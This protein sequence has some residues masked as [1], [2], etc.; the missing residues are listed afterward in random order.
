MKP[1]PEQ[2]KPVAETIAA[3]GAPVFMH[4]VGDGP[5]PTA[6]IARWR[7]HGA[8]FDVTASDAL[9]VAISMQ[10]VKYIWQQTG[11]VADRADIGVGSLSV[12][13][14]HEGIRVSVQG[15]ADVLRIF[16]RE[17]FLDA[18]VDGQFACLALFNSHDSELLAAAMQLFVAATR[19][20]PDDSLLLESG[21]HR[22]AARLVDR[23]GR[24]AS[25]PARGG[26][27]RTARRRVDDMVIAALDDT[28]SQSLTLGALASAACLSVNH[29]IRA[30]H[31]QTGVTPHRHVVLRRLERAIAL[32]KKPGI[33]VGEVADGVGFATPAHFVATFR[34]TLGVTP[35]AFRAALLR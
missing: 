8:E 35:G 28:T 29:F 30:F 31:Q 17:T 7:H 26:L 24:Q 25:G 3:F 15:E 6:V 33:S 19:G 2:M 34:R 16:L 14:P 5:S 4:A 32:L 21:V 20:D 12:L 22:L 27:A 9:C 23:D 13:P 11:K 10:D 18:A 1:A